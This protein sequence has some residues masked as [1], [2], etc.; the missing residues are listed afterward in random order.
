MDRMRAPTMF[1]VLVLFNEEVSREFEF[2]M[3]F[4]AHEKARLIAYAMNAKITF[5]S[6]FY[7]IHD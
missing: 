6:P 3:A 2:N 4:F 1:Y 7:I 5:H